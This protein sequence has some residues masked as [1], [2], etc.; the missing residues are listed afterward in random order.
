M[1]LG[2]RQDSRNTLSHEAIAPGALPTLVFVFMLLFC[3]TDTIAYTYK[4]SPWRQRQEALELETSP[5]YVASSFIIF[6]K[7]I[8]EILELPKGRDTQGGILSGEAQS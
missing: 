2:D 8:C 7:I 5:G 6:F 1:A 4:T 3:K